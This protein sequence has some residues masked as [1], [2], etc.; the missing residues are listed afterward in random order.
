MANI[1]LIAYISNI[2]TGENELEIIDLGKTNMPDEGII[3][4]VN[5]V[6]GFINYDLYYSYLDLDHFKEL[7]YATIQRR[8]I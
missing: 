1:Y 6:Y 5:N 2:Y 3:E 8:F 7:C 4:Y